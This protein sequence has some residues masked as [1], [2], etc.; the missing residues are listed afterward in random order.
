MA[1]R[2]ET[3]KIRVT[4]EEKE[5]I[6]EY[7][8]ESQEAA[9]IS[10]FGR[11]VLRRYISDSDEEAT[12]D[13]EEIIDAMDIALSDVHERLEKL[14]DHILAIEGRTSKEDEIDKLARNIYSALPVCETED[15]LASMAD[16][17]RLEDADDFTLAQMLST[18]NAWAQ[19]YGIDETMARRACATML[20]YYPDAHFVREEMGGTHMDFGDRIGEVRISER[21]YYKT[22]GEAGG[23]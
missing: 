7:M 18:P 19:Y 17:A 8:E 20:E 21:R 11:L 23:A 2:T 13:T 15:D 14:D 22:E 1:N 5:D 10:D 16:V 3:L 4:P 12:I 6:I 9:T